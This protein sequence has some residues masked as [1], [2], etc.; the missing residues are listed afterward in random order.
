MKLTEMNPFLRYA[1]L[2]YPSLSSVPFCRAYDYRLFYVLEGRADLILQ[3]RSV[4]VGTGSLI[5]LRP[6]VPYY[7]EGKIKVIV[8]NFDLTRNQSDKTEPINPLDTLNNFDERLIFENDPPPELSELAV[9]DNS[10]E[11]GSKIQECRLHFCYP[12]PYS[13]VLTSSI[14]KY[15]L[16]YIVGQTHKHQNT[17]PELIQRVMLYIQQNCDRELSNAQIS[18]K[19]GYHPYYLN[20]IF[21]QNTGITL[22]QALIAERIGIAK[23]LLGSTS[24]SIDAVSA[25]IGFS[26]RAQFSTAFKK[27]VGV[28]PSEYRKSTSKR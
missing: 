13:D 8:L 1:G 11:M 5:Y 17:L 24:L 6:S 15:I 22:H 16:C 14:V 23:K 2:Q 9:I 19:F 26:D 4:P 10:F 28:T 21:R 18:D 7:F 27:H 25:E 3:D 12:T 20:R